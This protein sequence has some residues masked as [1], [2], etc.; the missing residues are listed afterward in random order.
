[1]VFIY[2]FLPILLLSYFLIRK[3]FKNM[4]LLFSSIF[5]YAWGE[6]RLLWVLISIIAINYFTAVLIDKYRQKD[7]T[8]LI[9]GLII[10][11]SF[12]AYFKYTNF[13]IDNIALL[14]NSNFKIGKIALPLGISFFTFQAMSYIIDVY[15]KEVE[16]Q[17]NFYKLALYISIF[18]ALIA[19]PI[20]KYRDIKDQ[21]DN[22]DIS[23]DKFFYGVKRF[24]IGLSKK[25][26]I[27]NSVGLVA[28][29]VFATPINGMEIWTVW[30]GAICYTLQIYYDFSGYSDMAIGLGM[31]FGFRFL[32]NFNY[33]YISK[34][35][36]E[37]WR[38]WHIS[39]STWFKQYLYIPLGGNRISNN[40]T[41]INLLIV[42]LITG[43]WH[44]AAWN[45]I[46]WGLWY[47]IFLVFEKMTNW[48]KKEGGLFLSL[49]K[50]IYTM[51]IVVIGWVMFRADNMDY[52]WEYIK[53][54]FGFGQTDNILFLSGWYFDR[55]EIIMFA[56]GIILSFPILKNI[57]NFQVKNKLSII[58]SG[59][60]NFTLII[61]FILS[62]MSIASATFNPF[63]YFRF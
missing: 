43:F 53:K 4:L 34:S 28:D 40:R 55:F 54:M 17:K 47:G 30:L 50:R 14:T 13:F 46:F 32:E 60:V 3:E 11:L 24:I 63:I 44:G 8:I 37:F 23:L 52:A 16:I 9:I 39:L 25:V 58:I 41:N 1:M 35:I 56:I 22:H 59:G 62:T 12:F 5:F 49:I 26:L 57:L 18:P 33:P 7:K 51:L 38:R 42:F 31:M 6:P 45:F 10:N 2:V 21:I 19:G 15:R 61:L 29:K 27:A 20:I 36:T 48:H